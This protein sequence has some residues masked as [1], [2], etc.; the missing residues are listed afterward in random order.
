M[1]RLL[2]RRGM[3]R[4]GALLSG[5]LVT[6]LALSACADIPQPARPQL[7]PYERPAVRS[8]DAG[9]FLTTY[10][11]SLDQALGEEPSALEPLQTGPLLERTRAEMLIAEQSGTTL[12][13]SSYTDVVAGGPLFSEYPMWFMAF[14]TPEGDD[15]EEVQAML[16]TRDSAAADWKVAES[17]FVPAEAQPTILADQQGAVEQAPDAH[18]EAADALVG[19]AS[20]YLASGD[21]PEGGP[22]FE[23]AGFAD[24]RDYVADLGADD[25]GFSDVGVECAPYEEVPLGD[26]ALATEGG[27]VSFAES[28]CTLTVNVPESYFVDL[29]DEIEAVMTTDS[30]GSVITID[31]AQP[32][33]ITTAGDTASVF[34]PGWYM[35]SSETSDGGGA[36]EAGDD[37]EE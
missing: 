8:G 2:R 10:A 30:E 19:Q 34:S 21:V 20:E 12:G 5:G 29:G 4:F 3:K 6:G 23:E 32:M 28:R 11:E 36:D 24:F 37:G 27:G 31:V 22:N 14:A 13:A 15:S 35:L 33:L 1:G 9:S 17:L 26:Y 7:T 18:S 16:A 25:T